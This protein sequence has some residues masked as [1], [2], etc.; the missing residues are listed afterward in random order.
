MGIKTSLQQIHLQKHLKRADLKVSGRE[1]S[2]P[3]SKMS[4]A[5]SA[6]GPAPRLQENKP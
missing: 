4:E 5:L 3:R 1:F 6:S 2:A